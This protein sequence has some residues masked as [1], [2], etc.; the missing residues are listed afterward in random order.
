M[1]PNTTRPRNERD[2][3]ASESRYGERSTPYTSRPVRANAAM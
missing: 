1:S 3:T 2:A